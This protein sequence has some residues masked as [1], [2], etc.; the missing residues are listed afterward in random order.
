MTSVADTCLLSDDP[1][2]EAVEGYS[3]HPADADGRHHAIG[4]EFVEL[5]AT[6]I[7]RLRRF[8]RLQEHSFHRVIL[9][10]C[11]ISRNVGLSYVTIKPASVVVRK[12]TGRSIRVFSEIPGRVK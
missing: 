4:H 10:P 12:W 9:S 7:Q 3:E 6:E 8:H 2:A 11:D 1:R 5:A